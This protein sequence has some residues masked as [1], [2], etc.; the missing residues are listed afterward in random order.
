MP[1][2]ID[3]ARTAL[4]IYDMTATL[5]EGPGTEPWIVS[6][7]PQ[8]AELLG[9]CRAAGVFV[10][11]ANS[12]QGYAGFE[13]PA[14]IAPLQDEARLL[15]SGSGAFSGTDLEQ[16]LR[17]REVDTVMVAGM[18]VDRGCNMTARQAQNLGFRV[19]MV[20]GACFTHSIAEGPFGPIDKHEIE[21]VHL[22]ALSRMG[23][24]VPTIAEIMAELRAG[25]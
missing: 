24:G 18:A 17:D 23:I 13:I 22:A 4:V 11:Y 8:L 15:H 14:A 6:D 19:I 3:P 16:L 20:R 21:R 25:G 2:G 9:Q 10:C 5:L 12:A 1:D 7:L